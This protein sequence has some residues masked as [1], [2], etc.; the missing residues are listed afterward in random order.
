MVLDREQK[1]PVI[2][3]LSS[4]PRAREWM[5]LWSNLFQPFYPSPLMWVKQW[6]RLLNIET[7]RLKSQFIFS[8]K[9]KI[10]LKTENLVTGIIYIALICNLSYI[11]PNISK[12]DLAHILIRW[13]IPSTSFKMSYALPCS[14]ALWVSQL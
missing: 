1:I 10:L 4:L 14:T 8:P 13:P 12:L 6:S 5:A 11:K 9:R 7:I 2:E 3:L